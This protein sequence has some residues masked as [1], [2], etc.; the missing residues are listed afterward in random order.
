MGT[1]TGKETADASSSTPKKKRDY[2]DNDDHSNFDFLS[3]YDDNHRD[4]DTESEDGDD[5][6]DDTYAERDTLCSTSSEEEDDGFNSSSDEE[7]TTDDGRKHTSKRG[8]AKKTTND[9]SKDETT[10]DAD[11]WVSAITEVP[12][13]LRYWLNKVTGESRFERPLVFSKSTRRRDDDDD[14]VEDARVEERMHRPS[15]V[16]KKNTGVAKPQHRQ[17]GKQIKNASKSTRLPWSDDEVVILCDSWQKGQSHVESAIHLSYRSNVDVKDK[18]RGLLRLYKTQKAVLYNVLEGDHREATAYKRHSQTLGEGIGQRNDKR[19]RPLESV[20]DVDEDDDDDDNAMSTD[21]AISTDSGA[22]Y[23]KIDKDDRHRQSGS[24]D[25]HDDDD[26]AYNDDDESSDNDSLFEARRDHGGETSAKRGT[27]HQEQSKRVK[28]AVPLPL[29]PEARP[30]GVARA[31]PTT[32]RKR[33]ED[34]TTGDARILV[35]MK[36]NKNSNQDIAKALVDST[37]T[38]LQVSV[39]YNNLQKAVPRSKELTI[40]ERK[41]YVYNKYV[42]S[43][44]DHDGNDEDENDDDD[45]ETAMEGTKMDTDTRYL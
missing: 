28:I 30:A 16:L 10:S 41:K 43:A 3:N 11:D 44:A 37:R 21:D 33:D 31:N 13:G 2:N 35:F 38:P 26:D 45:E 14:D 27:T 12:K 39:K 15:G 7:R 4:D 23:D 20:E 1:S 29:I 9:L 19:S 5:S 6:T 42:N 32:A 22:H 18:K 25:I 34:W 17:R 36:H 8:G 40:D 24:T